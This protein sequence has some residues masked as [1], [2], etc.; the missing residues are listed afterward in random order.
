MLKKYYTIDWKI[1]FYCF[2]IGGAAPK[3][4]KFSANGT[5]SESLEVFSFRKKR[6]NKL[7]QFLEFDFRRKYTVFMLK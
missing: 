3:P 7:I 1:D 5:N 2:S 4:P 6:N